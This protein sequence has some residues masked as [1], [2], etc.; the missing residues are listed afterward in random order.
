[1]Q[2]RT[3]IIIAHRL[4]TIQHA[5]EIVV[6]HQGQIVERGRHETLM[7]GKGLYKKFIE[8]QKV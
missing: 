8:I 5:D 4:S 1:M 6:I 3:S 7:E 2:N